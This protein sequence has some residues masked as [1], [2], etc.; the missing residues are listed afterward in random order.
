M[1]QL[2][3]TDLYIPRLIWI[4]RFKSW[5]FYLPAKQGT[6][7]IHLTSDPFELRV[8][9]GMVIFTEFSKEYKPLDI[10]GVDIYINDKINWLNEDR[11]G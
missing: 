10:A 11:A 4:G 5:G 9:R 6:L 2:E 3:Q 7:R 8:N 1:A